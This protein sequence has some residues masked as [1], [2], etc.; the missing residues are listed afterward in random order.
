MMQ[1]QSDSFG[2]FQKLL[3]NFSSSEKNI[4][5]FRANSLKIFSSLSKILT[6]IL[7]VE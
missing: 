6:S 7:L 5:T 4:A 1:G 3:E 2:K